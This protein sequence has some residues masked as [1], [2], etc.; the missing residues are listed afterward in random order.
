MAQ[1]RREVMDFF[2][3]LMDA[4]FLEF[5]GA[6]ETQQ[7]S[8]M[9]RFAGVHLFGAMME[10]TTTWLA[11]GLPS[12]A[13]SSSTGQRISVSPWLNMYTRRHDRARPGTGECV[14][15]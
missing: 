8:E 3:N 1:R 15:R 5:F 14:S 12:L 9:L 7:V 11:G 4:Q 2:L 6:A 10:T 13:T